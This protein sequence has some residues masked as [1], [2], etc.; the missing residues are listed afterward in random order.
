MICDLDTKWYD[1]TRQT[2][3]AVLSNI[4]KIGEPLKRKIEKS[5][6]HFRDILIDTHNDLGGMR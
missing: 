1:K 6:E 5:F 2:F 3:D 4:P